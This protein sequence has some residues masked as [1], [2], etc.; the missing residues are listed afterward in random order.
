M[1]R[2]QSEPKPLWDHFGAK[3]PEYGDRR[4]RPL[5]EKELALYGRNAALER[6]GDRLLSKDRREKQA[7]KRRL[8]LARMSSQKSP[9]TR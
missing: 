8:R 4:R 1:P 9:G 7:R 5:T 2:K 6:Q 3:K